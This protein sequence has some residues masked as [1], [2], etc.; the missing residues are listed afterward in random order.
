MPP[1]PD[2]PT[3]VGDCCTRKLLVAYPDET[4]AA[5]LHRLS[6]RDIGRLP[7]VARDDPHHLLGMLRRSAMIRAY[8][9]ALSR[10]ATLLHK[11]HQVRLGAVGGIDIE[12]M[13]VEAG[14][15]CD[16]ARISEIPWP[17]ECVVATLRRGRQ[18][19]IP[20]GDTVLHAGDVLTVVLEGD[21]GEIA[22]AL[23]RA[24]DRSTDTE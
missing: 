7:V 10:R 16:E 2:K 18:S 17:Y 5:A 12:E 23:C 24:T 21:A 6:V 20:H 14:A 3:L 13:V 15:P 1:S 19:I 22:Q 11:V 4:L 8:D 9:L